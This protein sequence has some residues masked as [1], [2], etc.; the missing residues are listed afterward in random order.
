[1]IKFRVT[2]LDISGDTTLV[3]GDLTSGEMTLGRRDLKPSRQARSNPGQAKCESLLRKGQAEI[4]VFFEPCVY[5]DLLVI[6][7]TG[8]VLTTW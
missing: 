1:M 6:G 5:C 2:W 3:S 8:I 4:E 7:S